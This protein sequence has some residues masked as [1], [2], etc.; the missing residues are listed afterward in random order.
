MN[1]GKTYHVIGMMSGSSLDGVDIAYCKIT[2]GQKWKYKI[3]HANTYAYDANEVI[4]LQTLRSKTL[5]E[6][7]AYNNM[8]GIVFGTIAAQFISSYKIKKVD[9]IASHG[10]T[11]HHN[12]AKGITLQLG[13]G[14]PLAT[15]S[16]VPVVCNFREADV[17]AGGQGAPLVPICDQYFFSQYH[18]CLNIG[19][20]ANISYQLANKRIGFDICPANQLLDNLAR[21][22]N[23]PY[24]DK[25]KIAAG[26]KINLKLYMQLREKKYFSL[27]PPKSL[28][29][30]DIERI[31]MS[32]IKEAKC[33]VADKLRSATE[34]IATKIAAEILRHAAAEKI[35]LHKYKL[36]ISGGGA[37]NTF[38]IKQIE[39]MANITIQLP[40]DATIQ[41]KEALAMCLMG[42]LR[43]EKKANFIPAVTGAKRAVSGGAI[44][45][46]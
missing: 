17:K 20:I 31:F 13:A 11:I 9:F 25:G 22:L 10:H 16:G 46:P 39:R 34:M 15:A 30:A 29:N 6:K 24:D 40:D 23:K 38:L 7:E 42:I 18:A 32:T 43:W 27:A 37:Y 45:K 33:S 36:L 5:A 26:G 1:T 21:K 4:F 41:F 12:P 28:D 8:F 19:G 3:I 14:Q 2:T 35:N 44:F